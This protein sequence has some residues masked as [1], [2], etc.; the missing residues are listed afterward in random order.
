MRDFG[1]LRKILL[2]LLNSTTIP[3]QFM[4][5]SSSIADMAVSMD[6]AMHEDVILEPMPGKIS[7]HF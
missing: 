2:S 1:A 3:S 5:M 4:M 7:D 6:V